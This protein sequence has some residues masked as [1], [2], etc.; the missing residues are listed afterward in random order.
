M[1]HFIR[2][3]TSQRA[4][5][6]SPWLSAQR[7]ATTAPVAFMTVQAD[8]TLV[9]TC[10]LTGCCHTV[11]TADCSTLWARGRRSYADPPTYVGLLLAGRHIHAVDADRSRGRPWT[12]S[13]GTQNSC[14]YG[15]A[16]SCMHF[17]KRTAVL[18]MIFRRTGSQWRLRE[19]GVM[20]TCRGASDT[21]RA[22]VLCT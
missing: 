4:Q 13:A 10:S 9:E 2:R 17:H 20:W 15:G 16:T 6:L 21:K 5:R 7:N 18:K 19:T 8:E 3:S 14:R 22:V 1:S 12:F 11:L